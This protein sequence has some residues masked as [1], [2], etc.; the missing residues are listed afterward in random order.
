MMFGE[1]PLPASE[2]TTSIQELLHIYEEEK[3]LDDFE[4][5]LREGT[6]KCSDAAETIVWRLLTVAPADRI[7]SID[8]LKQQ[9]FYDGAR[10]ATGEPKTRASEGEGNARSEPLSPTVPVAHTCY[11]RAH[12][13]AS[14]A[15]LA[16]GPPVLRSRLILPFALAPVLTLLCYAGINWDDLYAL[17]IDGPLFCDLRPKLDTN[18]RPTLNGE[19]L[20]NVERRF[21]AFLDAEVIGGIQEVDLSATA[22]CDA[23]HSDDID[24][25]RKMYQA[26][27]DMNTGDYDKRTAMH[28]AASKGRLEVVRFLIEEAGAKH[29]PADR[30]GGTPLDDATR[31][32][33]T[34]VID[35]LKSKWAKKG[36]PTSG[37]PSQ[38]IDLSATAMCD[39]AHSDNI[40]ELRKTYHAG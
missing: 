13:R 34:H 19:Q 35:F 25:L 8:E 21:S 40:D 2:E 26:G 18:R 24:G 11:D 33:H 20:G 12:A 9:K 37:R 15:A 29:S 10:A 22:M 1:S 4:A 6:V 27:G 36:K 14:P 5:A 39:A 31:H 28:L 17:R 3:H 30:W 38:E 23:A 7:T 32:E 16:P